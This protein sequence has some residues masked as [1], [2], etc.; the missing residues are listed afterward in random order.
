[1]QNP[2]FLYAGVMTCYV[3]SAKCRHCMYASSPGMPKEFITRDA[4]RRVAKA[5]RDGGAR[6]VHIG[7]GEPFLHTQSLLDTCEALMQNGIGIDY[8]ETNAGWLTDGAKAEELLLQL[9]SF[10]AEAVMVS[11]DPFHGE[12][13]PV[14]KP[15]QLLRHIDAVPGMGSFIWQE[16]YVKRM[17]R[18]P[19]DRAHGRNEMRQVLGEKYDI[20]AA[21]EYGLG[22]NG[23][24]LLLANRMYPKQ[25][26]EDL[27]SS[28]ACDLLNGR[29]CHIDLYENVVPGGCPGIAIGMDDFALG[30]VPP[31]KYPVAVRL[32][33]GGISAFFDYAIQAGFTPDAD[34]YISKCELCYHMRRHLLGHLPSDDIGPK[35]FYD[36]MD[37]AYRE[38]P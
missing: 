8:I 5:L 34:G 19:M 29:H 22:I 21:R 15:L 36:S 16:K 7:G 24:A 35:C 6:S 23:R 26:T 38:G 30:K 27:L 33:T 1:M 2:R 3:C 31:E 28:R 18:L 37:A 13:I 32:L 14:A 17:T 10:G 25:K 9:K 20:E 11:I 4:A 12:Y